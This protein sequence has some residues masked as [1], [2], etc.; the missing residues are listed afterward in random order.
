MTAVKAANPIDDIVARAEEFMRNG[1]I[2]GNRCGPTPKRE[3]MG[4]K[5][6]KG[7]AFEVRELI[8]SGL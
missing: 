4:R 8:N 5:R 1:L 6:G 3:V 7:R 2:K